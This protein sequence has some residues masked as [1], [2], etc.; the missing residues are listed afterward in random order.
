MLYVYGPGIDSIKQQ[1]SKFGIPSIDETQFLVRSHFYIT[2]REILHKAGYNLQQKKTY[3][4]TEC[5][6]YCNRGTGSVVYIE[7]T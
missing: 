7:H 5:E 2:L 4:E 3:N 6:V 1:V